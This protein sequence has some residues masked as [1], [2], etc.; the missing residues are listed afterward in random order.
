MGSR[1]NGR[2]QPC[3]TLAEELQRVTEYLDMFVDQFTPF[4]REVM[5]RFVGYMQMLNAMDFI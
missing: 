3:N 4:E 1:P 5:N 2:K